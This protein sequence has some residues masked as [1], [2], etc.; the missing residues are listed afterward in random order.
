LFR[1]CDQAAVVSEASNP[2]GSL[3]GIA[4]VTNEGKNVFGMMPHPERAADKELANQDGRALFDSI[5]KCLSL[6]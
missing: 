6:V 5:I 2:N 1:Y 4:G 3:E